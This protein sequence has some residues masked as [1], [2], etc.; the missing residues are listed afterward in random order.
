M[1]PLLLFLTDGTVSKR[2][3][4]AQTRGLVLNEVIRRVDPQGRTLGEILRQDVGIPGIR[5]GF[6]PLMFLFFFGVFY[7]LNFSYFTK[8]ELNGVNQ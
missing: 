6:S 7:F 8:K 3:Y 1:D 5:Q 4:H 2:S